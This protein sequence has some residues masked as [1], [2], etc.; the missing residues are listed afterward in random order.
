MGLL[1]K[2][3][4]RRLVASNSIAANAAL[5]DMTATN[6][7]IGGLD[8]SAYQ[9]GN[10][11]IELTDSNGY[12][13][14]GY[15]S[16]TAPGGETLDAELHTSAN[17]ASD[18]NA[19]EANAITG[20]TASFGTALTSNSISPNVGTYHLKCANGAYNTYVITSISGAIYK[21]TGDTKSVAGNYRLG[22]WNGNPVGTNLYNLVISDLSHAYTSRSMY[23]TALSTTTTVL[24]YSTSGTVEIYLDN[25]S[26][27]RMTDCAATG[28]LIVS[29]RGGATRAWTSNNGLTGNLAITYKIY[30]LP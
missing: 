1:G 6:A 22:L 10:H 30:R 27:K 14:S 25:V 9:D 23:G 13:A 18:P 2:T 19:N 7:F 11:F 29:T 5:L 8:V 15:I 16:A 4:G 24:F 28:G 21:L 17:A 26:L 12:K 3:Q 20:W